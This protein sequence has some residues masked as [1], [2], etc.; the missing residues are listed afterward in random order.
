MHIETDAL[1]QGP[2]YLGLVTFFVISD[3]RTPSIIFYSHYS[4]LTSSY[5]SIMMIFDLIS[6]RLTQRLAQ[7][8]LTNGR[9][10]KE[11]SHSNCACNP[12][13]NDRCHAWP[14]EIRSETSN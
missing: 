3:I 9:R 5:P 12:T 4:L 14:K 8:V 2:A 10:C 1:Q 7:T 13:E 6:C 11:D